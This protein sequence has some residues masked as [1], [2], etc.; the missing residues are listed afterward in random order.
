MSQVHA[1]HNPQAVEAATTV[2]QAHPEVV[3]TTMNDLPGYEVTEIYGAVFGLTVRSRNVFKNM[4]ADFKSLV[5]GELG[6]L[7]NNLQTARLDA[8][9][10]LVGH[11]LSL[12]ANAILALRFDSSTG[13]A[14]G[15][16]IAVTAYGTAVKV[17]KIT[18]T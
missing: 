6:A 9:D 13:G 15:N 10:R 17:R 12:H 14:G 2:N 18:A 8:V 16:Q 5:G 4:G 11:A 1:E 3:V 7:S